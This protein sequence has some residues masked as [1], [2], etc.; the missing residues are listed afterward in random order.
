MRITL[1][2]VLLCSCIDDTTTTARSPATKSG[3]AYICYTHATCTAYDAAPRD[4]A[5]RICVQPS[6]SDALEPG[7]A[8]AE[9][10]RQ[11]WLGACRASE[12]TIDGPDEGRICATPDT[13]SSSGFAAA[14]YGCSADCE[15]LFAG[16]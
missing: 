16:C 10:Y 2:L 11:I 13:S 12:G 14:V 8:A 6:A 7:D 1:L 9:A 3:A 4:A 15:P 5:T